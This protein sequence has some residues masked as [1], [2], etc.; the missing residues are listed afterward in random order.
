SAII[1]HLWLYPDQHWEIDYVSAGAEEI[2]GYSQAELKIP[3][4]WISRILPG[5]WEAIQNQAFEDIFMERSNTYEYRFLRK[6]NQICWIA[7]TNHSH[8]DQTRQ[9][10]S[11]TIITMD[12]CDR[13]KAEEKLQSSEAALAEAQRIAHIGNWS[14]DLATQK[15]DWSAELFRMFGLDPSQPAPSYSEYFNLIDPPDRFALQE[16]IKLAITEGTPY[17]I[18]YKALLPDGSVRFHEGRG[19]VERDYQG[20][21][22]RLKGTG[23]DITARKVIELELM[24]RTEE[25]DRFFSVALD[26]LCIATPAGY[27]LR[28]NPQWEKNL[29]YPLEELQ[30]SRFL[31]YVHPDDLSKTLAAMDHLTQEGV[32]PNFVN[33]YRSQTGNYCWLEWRSV[34]VGN[35]IYAAARDISQQ[36]HIQD[37][38]K[39]EKERAEALT[40]A[41]SEFLA[42][43]SHEIRTPLSSVISI[44]GLLNTEDLKPEQQDLVTTL[45]YSSDTLLRILNDILDFSKI[46]SGGIILEKQPFSI[47]EEVS[48][49][50][51]LFEASAHEK[52]LILKSSIPLHFPTTFL[53][54]AARLRQILLNLLGNAIKFTETGSVWVIVRERS[55]QKTTP[56]D[57]YE[58]LFSVQD[59][60]IGIQSEQLEKLFAPF[61]QGDTSI[62]R[63][64]G[65][66]GLGLVISKR[67]VELMEGSL[68]V[69]SGGRVAG[70]PPAD[71][72][73]SI[74]S[75]NVPGATFYFTIVLESDQRSGL[76]K[77]LGADSS[78]ID[79][80][81]AGHYPLTILLA[82]DNIINRKVIQFSFKR[83]GYV[84]DMVDNGRKALEA[85]QAKHYDLVLM[86]MQMPEMDGL[87]ATRLIRSAPIK[88]P[89]ITALTANVLPQDRQAC[90]DA[91]MNGYETK[92]LKVERIQEICQ[93]LNPFSSPS[94]L[95]DPQ[96]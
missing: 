51:K 66:T 58:L 95:P 41:K 52:R 75:V 47:A 76:V 77:S 33:R 19:E 14:F 23:L 39:Q 79:P 91:G 57:C 2:S 90:F 80:R 34:M 83:L 96:I 17:I 49:I 84:I 31:D 63:Q 55:L 71:W 13:K 16:K 12:I 50:L 7:Q 64:Y 94:P 42:N 21:I 36:K 92:P 20:N 59:T 37:Q 61:S 78:T 3:N 32:L 40:R 6:D 56:I 25:L 8:W 68:W 38:L 46:E 93:D 29:G 85:V 65:G 87:T 28:L 74:N 30:G 27:F 53:G 11:V 10:W 67:L 70:S 81:F 15:I 45:S 43:M 82:D 4:L 18:D 22:I 9:A 24:Q 60:G 88:Q 86:D 26:L 5:D 73:P 72:Q 35:L 89:W 44:A 54:D 48:S 69:E 1:T 62:S